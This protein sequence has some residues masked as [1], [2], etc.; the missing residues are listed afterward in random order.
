MFVGKARLVIK[1]LDR[2]DKNPDRV[3]EILNDLDTIPL[4]FV[5]ISHFLS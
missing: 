1:G 4:I 5:Y 3:N 2:N